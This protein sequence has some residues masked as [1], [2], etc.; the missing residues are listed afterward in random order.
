MKT[1]GLQE[2]FAVKRAGPGLGQGLFAT[3][4]FA[5]EDFLLEY[6]GRHIP[7]KEADELETRYLF[8]LDN[9]WT[10]DGS[11]RGNTARYINH[12]CDPNCEA[13]IEDGRV[14]IFALSKIAHGEELTIDYGEE[15]F[16]EYIKPRGCKC[17]RCTTNASP[18]TQE[19][20][21][22]SV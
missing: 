13:R 12:S 16:D 22:S 21:L 6:K 9:V 15:Y 11:S 8:E 14:L 3:S 18:S 7:A 5:E 1:G 10:I 20:V 19:V 4:D 2:R 17:A